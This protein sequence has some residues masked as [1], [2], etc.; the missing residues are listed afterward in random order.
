MLM[1]A[2]MGSNLLISGRSGNFVVSLS[3][4]TPQVTKDV[5]MWPQFLPDGKHIL[6]TVFDSQLGRHRARVAKFGEPDTVK[7]L[8]E[9]DS[10][11][12]FVPSMVNSESGYLLSVRA[13]NLLAYPF[14]PRSLRVQ[15]EPTAIVSQV[16]SHPTG[17]A[18]FSASN[19]GTIAYKRLSRS[20]LARLVAAVRS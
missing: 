3:G 5:Y 14:D 19:N 10:R 18:D 2:V 1:G 17:A 15:G 8:L 6:Y 13:G 16:S 4:G 20:Q 12:E 11:V 9:T 7:E